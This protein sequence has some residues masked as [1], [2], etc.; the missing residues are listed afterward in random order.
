MR[1]SSVK[2]GQRL[3]AHE[4]SMSLVSRARDAPELALESALRGPCASAVQQLTAPAAGETGGYDSKA[5]WYGNAT[6]IPIG[7]VE[8]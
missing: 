1:I 3:R 8:L 6:P 7:R 2:Q 5:D 4:S